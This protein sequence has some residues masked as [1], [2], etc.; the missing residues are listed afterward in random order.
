MTRL[1]LSAI[2]ILISTHLSVA[3]FTLSAEMRPRTQ[4][5][6]GYRT[7]KSEGDSPSFFT[8][9]RTR[10]NFL[11]EK[12]KLFST[13]ISVQD[14][15]VW[16]DQD[17]L[18]DE[19]SVG[20]F[21]AWAK[22]RI[23]D[24]LHLKA[25]RQELMY[26]DGYLL[27]HLNWRQTGRSHDAALLQFA[28][29]SFEADLGLAFNQDNGRI[30]GTYYTGN[31]YKSLQFLWMK[32]SWQ[33]VDLSLLAI[34]R[35]F[36]SVDSSQ[37]FEQTF[38]PNLYYHNGDFDLKL[39]YYFQT[40][41][42]RQQRNVEAHF[43]S[44]WVGYDLSDKWRWQLGAD[45]LSGMTYRQANDPFNTE[46]NTFDILYGL[47]HGHFGHMDYFYLGFTP[48][49]GLVDV[50]LKGT[51]KPSAKLSITADIHSFSS[52]ADLPPEAAAVPEQRDKFLG[53]ETDLYAR[54]RLDDELT[55]VGGYSHMFATESMS[56]VKGGPNDLL[57]NWFWVSLSFK[58]IL[59]TS[60][61]R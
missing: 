35:G 30:Y 52:Y 3:Q 31:Y 43:F 19:P 33:H 44:G 58:P 49:A 25:G 60:S 20:V 9:Q 37:V 15:R 13:Y 40:G 22:L 18:A 45:V 41:T 57:N 56:I 39:R 2:L 51:Y 5:R 17:Q 24:K 4:L 46:N 29:S 12:D 50:V 21:Q 34:N 36:Q 38:G 54:Y 61:D 47:R 53:V 10:L 55:L 42:D 27:G 28:D 11:Y 7:L 32:K 1:Y 48:P 8:S 23:I 6:N 14:V 59:F 16:G 26:E